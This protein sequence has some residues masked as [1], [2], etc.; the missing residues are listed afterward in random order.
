ME[1]AYTYVCVC[2]YGSKHVHLCC[3]DL[4]SSIQLCVVV[5]CGHKCTCVIVSCC[6]LQLS[7]SKT[8]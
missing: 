4:L 5:D 7:R 1:Q 2:S 3:G 6:R 8:E